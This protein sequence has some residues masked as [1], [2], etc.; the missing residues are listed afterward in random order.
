MYAIATQ[1]NARNIQ[2]GMVIDIYGDERFAVERVDVK[3]GAVQV[4]DHHGWRG[5]GADETV[6]VAGYFNA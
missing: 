5:L 2:P 4:R 6:T 3:W 1:I